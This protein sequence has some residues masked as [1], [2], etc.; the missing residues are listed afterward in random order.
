[1]CT[2]FCGGKGSQKVY[3][4]YT[5]ENVDIYGRPLKQN[6]QID[7]FTSEYITAVNIEYHMN[8]AMTNQN[9]I[10]LFQSCLSDFQNNYI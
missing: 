7:I 5:H 6:Q 1:M 2:L 8:V 4:L 9:I 10:S 3:G